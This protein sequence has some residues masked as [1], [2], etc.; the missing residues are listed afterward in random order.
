MPPYSSGIV[1]PNR[2]SSFICSTIGSGNE[3]S[4]SYFSAFGRICS[5]ANWRTISV[6]AFCSS[7]L[8]IVAGVATAMGSR[9]SRRL[10]R[11]SSAA[12]RIP[13]QESSGEAARG[14]VARRVA[15]LEARRRAVVLAPA[16]SV[17]GARLVERGATA[18]R[19]VEAQTGDHDVG[20]AGVRVDGDP[21][22]GARLAPRHEAARVERA[23][24]EPTAVERVADGAGAVVA[25]IEFL[26][27]RSKTL[28]NAYGV[29]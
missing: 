9:G 29:S 12:R 22:A 7:V 5:S 3:S 18:G 25:A 28:S 17:A 27:R 23:L 6:I 8:S 4:W 24:E 14:L 2:P 16:R 11:Q 15:G 20:V 19:G 13:A 21:V 1:V 26:G 10:I